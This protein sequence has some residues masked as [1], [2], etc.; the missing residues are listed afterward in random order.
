MKIKHKETKIETNLSLHNWINDYVRKGIYKNWEIIS[1][2]NV[3]KLYRIREK[4]NYF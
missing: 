2:E 3:V 1:F 4:R